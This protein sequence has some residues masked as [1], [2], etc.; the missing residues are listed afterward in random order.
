MSLK[1]ALIAA[2]GILMAPLVYADQMGPNGDKFYEEAAHFENACQHTPCKRGY[3][4]QLTYSYSQNINAISAKDLARLKDIARVQAAL[5]DPSF[6]EKNLHFGQRVF[7]YEVLTLLKKGHIIGY[8]IKYSLKAW[9]LDT[10]PADT[11]LESLENC[12][13]GRISEGSYV[14]ADF[15]TYFSDEERSISFRFTNPVE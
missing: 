4:H 8:K 10:C 6:F 14:S 12:K 15:L 3:D 9:D 7:L 13:S 5:W 2:F 1:S 11:T